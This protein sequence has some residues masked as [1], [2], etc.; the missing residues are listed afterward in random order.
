M[1]TFNYKKWVTDY[2]QGKPLFE[3]TTGSYTGSYSTGSF[4]GSYSTGSYTGSYTGSSS[5]GSSSTGSGTGSGCDNSPNSQC[6]QTYF[7]SA[8]ANNFT[9]YMSN[10]SC[11]TYQSTKAN[12]QAGAVQLAQNSPNGNA[13]WTYNPTDYP[14][15]NQIKQIANTLFGQGGAGQPQKR[16]FKRKAAKVGWAQCLQNSGCC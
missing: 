13:N 15:Y 1:T 6:A 10:Q 7:G 4:T 2:K 16:Q 12:N 5:T 11:T 14:D 3:Q 8:N 9:N